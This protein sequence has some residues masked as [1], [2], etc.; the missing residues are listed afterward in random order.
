M[1][2]RIELS[3][4][5][6]QYAIEDLANLEAIPAIDK[7]HILLVANGD[8]PSMHTA[9][10][11]DPAL[12]KDIQQPDI[13]SMNKLVRIIADLKLEYEVETQLSTEQVNGTE[14]H[15][16]RILFY[17][18][19]RMSVVNQLIGA[20]KKGDI[21]REGSLLGFPK[22]AVDAYI[23]DNVIEVSHWPTSTEHVTADEMKFLN[24]MISNDNWKDEVKYL[25]EYARTTRLISPKIYDQCVSS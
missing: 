21:E 19:R 16:T 3:D 13:D 25:P 24:H 15:S 5:A 8:K 12:V 11:T 7:A 9:L 17:I 1:T 20:R 4:T 23:S 18:A 10:F 6:V 14:M 22:S 2:T